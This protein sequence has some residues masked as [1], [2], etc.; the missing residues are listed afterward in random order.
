MDDEQQFEAS[1]LELNPQ[2]MTLAGIDEQAEPENEQT[3]QEDA[4]AA[5]EL[6]DDVKAEI[7]RLT[8][9]NSKLQADHE[10]MS[11]R[12]GAE[13]SA[14]QAFAKLVKQQLSDGLIDEEQA[15]SLTGFDMKRIQ[16]LLNSP[17]IADNPFEAQKQAFNQ[18]FN[19][20]KPSFDS[21]YKTDTGAY[22]KAFGDLADPQLIQHFI[23]MPSE[24]APAFVLEKGK[25]LLEKF[26]SGGRDAYIA[27][28][29]A[30]IA[31]LKAGKPIEQKVNVNSQPKQALLNSPA[32]TDMAVSE[33]FKRIFGTK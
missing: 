18:V 15:K 11:G 19:T 17:E 2:G 22:A 5:P 6:P 25:E 1:A 16:G 33:D 4:P 26:G 9:A 7:E 30:D 23:E 27:K 21:I 12:L 8:A 3:Q 29:E 13:K 31:A 32:I 20:L 24:E 10:R 28:L 14:K